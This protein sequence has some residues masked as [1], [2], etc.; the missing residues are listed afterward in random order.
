MDPNRY[1]ALRRFFGG[2]LPPARSSARPRIPVR[3]HETLGALPSAAA[4]AVE[5]ELRALL[6][7]P[8]TDAELARLLAA[9]GRP[10][11]PGRH[12]QS[13]REWLTGQLLHLEERLQ[14]EAWLAG[15]DQPRPVRADRLRPRAAAEV[16]RVGMQQ[17]A[18]RTRLP[19]RAIRGLLDGATPLHGDLDPFEFLEPGPYPD[20]RYLVSCYFYQSYDFEGAADD[21]RS[22]VDRFATAEQSGL[23][24]GVVVDIGRLLEDVADDAALGRIVQD[25]G[26]C[27]VPPRWGLTWRA[28]LQAV[29]DHLASRTTRHRAPAKNAEDA[30]Y[31]GLGTMRLTNDGADLVTL[32]LE[33]W[34]SE[35]PVGA[36]EAIEVREEGPHADD[37]LD[38]QVAAG[39]IVL[40]ARQGTVLRA[41]KDGEELA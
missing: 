29:R 22:V 17:V 6:A 20:L 33:P 38:I 11:R 23:A 35:Y 9:W 14:R 3:R 21:W 8:H 32:V 1:P 28:W 5:A 40:R 18:D 25:L 39:R 19:V 30:G 16:A 41:F 12:G 31:T 36:G 13:V 34:G 7:E 24:R 2:S 26:C 4:A 10:Y 27:F 37:L 15:F